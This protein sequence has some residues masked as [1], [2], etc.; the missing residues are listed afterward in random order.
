LWQKLVRFS[1]WFWVLWKNGQTYESAGMLLKVT[2]QT[3]LPKLTVTWP[4]RVIFR[5]VSL[6]CFRIPFPSEIIIGLSLLGILSHRCACH[7]SELNVVPSLGLLS[8]RISFLARAGK[9]ESSSCVLMQLL[10]SQSQVWTL[11]LPLLAVWSNTH[12]LTLCL[13]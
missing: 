1:F 4:W 8:I 13:R 12:Y 9:R 5:A 6:A 10:W 11:A 3:T 2:L 7:R